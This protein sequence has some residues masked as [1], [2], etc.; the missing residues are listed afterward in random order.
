MKSNSTKSVYVALIGDAISSA[1]IDL[2]SKA[3][4]LGSV[5]IGLYTYEALV[6]LGQQ[7]I[8]KYVDRKAVVEN[9]KQV[10][11]VVPQNTASYAANIRKYRPD[12]VVHGDDWL[13][14]ASMNLRLEVVSEL[15]KIGSQLIEVPYNSSIGSLTLSSSNTSLSDIVVSSQQKLRYLLS[16]GKTL[17]VLEAHSA[18]CALIAEHTSATYSGKVVSFDGLW[19][20]SL[21]DA[22]SKGKPDIEA[23]DLTSRLRAVNEI[24]EVS[25]KPLIFDADT[26]GKVEHFSLNI[27]TLER[28]GVSAVVIEDKTGLKK[29]S[30]LGNDVLQTQDT[31]ANFSNKIKVGKR[32]QVS[33]ALMIIARI[34][35]LILGA[36]MK[37]ALDRAASYV[38]AGADGIM[39]HSR[40]SD[41]KEIK[42]FVSQFRSQNLSTP[43]VVVPTSFNTVTIDEFEDMGVNIVIAANHM[44][45]ASYPAMKSVA[46]LILKKG[47]TFEAD[48][49]CMSIKD[50]LSFIPGTI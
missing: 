32:A 27:K 38:E 22:T 47:R 12:F 31:I 25:S 48:E 29:N 5:I 44:L 24:L 35:S 13:S 49:N 21:T 17:R 33:D 16:Q 26:G 2:L 20:S 37:D 8:L 30:L 14:S 19:S 6:E 10:S 11:S 9:L 34:E 28:S 46:E 40:L 50:I 7:S 3:R 45:R 23:V 36:G 42:E 4:E 41:P 1:H 39:I 18:L 43:L 15:D